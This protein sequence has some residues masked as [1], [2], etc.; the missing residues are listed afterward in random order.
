MI[1]RISLLIGVPAGR[2]ITAWRIS[3]LSLDLSEPEPVGPTVVGLYQ[4]VKEHG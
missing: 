2:P 4:S 3:K 1:R